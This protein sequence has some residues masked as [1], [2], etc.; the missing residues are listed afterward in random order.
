MFS[1]TPSN[2]ISTKKHI[3]TTN[4][5]MMDDRQSGSDEDENDNHDVGMNGSNKKIKSN[6]TKGAASVL[7][8]NGNGNMRTGSGEAEN[9]S[10]GKKSQHHTVTSEDA[11]M[12]DK[13]KNILKRE[14]EGA[15]SSST[16]KNNNGEIKTEKNT[17]VNSNPATVP[18]LKGV[19][20]YIDNELTKK[21]TIVG[22]WNFESSTESPQPFQLTRDLEPGEDPTELPKD[23]EFEGTF[24]LI[25]KVNNKN[26]K[27]KTRTRL[28]PENGVKLFFTKQAGEENIYDIN[29]KGKNDYGVFSIS[30][31]AFRDESVSDKEYNVE[32]RKRYI[33]PDPTTQPVAN[34][35]G[36]KSKGKSKKRKLSSTPVSA[37]KNEGP[38]PDPSESFPSNVVCLRGKASR[39]S[40]VQDGVVHN[41]RG[42]WSTGLDLVLSD[43]KNEH[44][45]CNQFEYEH[46][47][48]VDTDVFPVSGRY[49]GWFNFTEDGK[50]TRVTE[51]DV[52][53]KF[54]KNNAGYFNV[55]GKG[56]NIFGKYNISG[57]LN[58]ENVIT[59]FR[60]FMPAK[61]KKAAVP[62]VAYGSLEIGGK[63]L[64]L[65][66]VDV[67]DQESYTPIE[68]PAD[69]RYQALSRGS[70]KVNEDGFH[71]CSGKWASN[72]ANH[73]SNNS[74][75]VNFGLEEHHAKQA[76]EDM[77]RKGLID[78]KDASNIKLFPL[79]SANYKGS[80][81]MKKGTTPVIDK[82]IVLKFRKNTQGSY[83]VYGKGVNAYGYF[84][85]IGTLV[86]MGPSG[87]NIEL[88]RIYA[89]APEQPLVP[90]QTHPKGKSLP[91]A[92]NAPTK[93]QPDKTK[94]QPNLPLPT[95]SLIRRESSRQVKVPSHLA[96]DDP[97]ANKARMMDKCSAIL[98]LIKEKD[99][100]GLFLE[101]VDPVAHGIPTYHQV[102]TNPMDLGT[103]QSKMDAN[104]IESP[105]EF[106][107]LV[108]LVFENA[109]KFNSNPM[110][111]VNETARSLL[112]HFNVKFRDVERLM[113]KP[114]KTELK[115]IKKKQQREEKKRLEKERK[116]RR[117][118]DENPKVKQLS[119]LQAS[120]EDVARS[121]A[122]LD[123]ATS[124]E[125]AQ[126]PSVV[127]RNEFNAMTNVLKQMQTQMTYIE[128]LIHDL[129]NP[130]KTTSTAISTT[131][132][133][134]SGGNEGNPPKKPRKTKRAP[135]A[136]AKASVVPEPKILAAP[137]PAPKPA[138]PPVAV[139]PMEE[140]PLTHQEQEE[141]T[142]AINEM[143]EDKITAVI[144][145]IKRSKEA[146]NLIDDD[147]EIELELD[148]LD[149]ATQ[150]KLLKFAMK[151]CLYSGWYLPYFLL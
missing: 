80:F 47:S 50:T 97:A 143:S 111:F 149:S 135:K 49:T 145:I 44:G 112:S 93:K 45:F 126:S 73:A 65:D 35:S 52:V 86:T 42:L 83:N 53:L 87:G 131:S 90:A 141:L 128:A 140:E 89:P 27:T 72:R 22:K 88:F 78:D 95:S 64:T 71:T 41:I 38:L 14:D 17:N 122:T 39:D 48:T 113:K 119:L 84:D 114:T 102:I 29:G 43:P 139:P 115:E 100:S 34:S 4:H 7:N 104:E 85:L 23:G 54:K 123:L 67:P 109:V 133:A 101:P 127:S 129:V 146:S 134:S 116:R 9:G 125:E 81:K 98:T 79:D 82:Q 5:V 16:T 2:S 76:I 40:S 124:T 142:M 121:L 94:T 12:S 91:T 68:P 55:E 20:T 56:T 1:A 10:N 60:H 36:K 105:E 106:A 132:T 150:R 11:S 63:S 118:E 92:K 37:E 62:N 31:T 13:S 117:E 21:H 61:A 69:G 110:N 6:G 33:I 75:N 147:Q 74:S 26:G 51:K 30:G 8:G 120:S 57:T 148:Q 18:L 136:Q 130:N 19:M 25:Y 108:R 66:D 103:I 144:E 15:S 137:A 99:T 138:S 96:D 24:R 151:V 3:E 46:R 32:F 28:V 70:F 58:K 107:R 77:K 59:L